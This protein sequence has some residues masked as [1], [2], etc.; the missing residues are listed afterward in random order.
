MTDNNSFLAVAIGDFNAQS[1]SWC[2]NDKSNYEGSK[3]DC[4]ATE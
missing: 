1:S 4:L 3:I 2:F